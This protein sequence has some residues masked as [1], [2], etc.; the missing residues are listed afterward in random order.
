M[1]RKILKD[2]EFEITLEKENGGNEVLRYELFDTSVTRRWLELLA[3]DLA[4]ESSIENLDVAFYSYSP[5]RSERAKATLRQTLAELDRIDERIFTRYVD[6]DLTE[7][8]LVEIHSLKEGLTRL[9]L[10]DGFTFPSY[11]WRLMAKL[12]RAIHEIEFSGR[13]AGN[14]ASV[15]VVPDYASREPL[16]M[17]ERKLFEMD[18]LGGGLYLDYGTNGVPFLDAYVERSNVQLHRT[19][20]LKLRPMS[21]SA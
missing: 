14:D 4:K 20:P 12:N 10:K 19:C 3:K 15:V 1:T 2:H 9:A 7:V 18:F 21:R 13:M 8:D 17:E 5:A 16:T 6:R 11:Y